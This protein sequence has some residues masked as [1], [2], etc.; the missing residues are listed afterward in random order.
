MRDLPSYPQEIALAHALCHG[1]VFFL[2]G[3]DGGISFTALCAQDAR[4]RRAW[5]PQNVPK[6]TVFL[7]PLPIL[8]ES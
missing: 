2:S 4:R 6:A 5:I 1:S 8:A 3:E 7:I